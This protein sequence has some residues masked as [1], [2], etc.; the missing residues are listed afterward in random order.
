MARQQSANRLAPGSS[1][2]ASAWN[3]RAA[4]CPGQRGGSSTAG[5]PGS[6]NRNL[7][8]SWISELAH[9]RLGDAERREEPYQGGDRAWE[10]RLLR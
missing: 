10:P 3:T 6:L 9:G 7:R 1:L 4:S 5:N 8:H 2:A